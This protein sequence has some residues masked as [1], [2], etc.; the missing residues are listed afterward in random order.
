[1]WRDKIMKRRILYILII[2]VLLSAGIVVYAKYNFKHVDRNE[3]FKNS[4]YSFFASERDTINNFEGMTY[5]NMYDLG[6]FFIDDKVKSLKD[7]EENSEY[8]LI[9]NSSKYPTFKGNGII[10]NCQIKKVIKG[11]D[12][13]ENEY[14]KIYDLVAFW[15]NSG[16]FYLGGSTPIKREK[17]YIVFL[18]STTNANEPNSYVYSSVKYGHVSISE[19]GKILENYKQNSLSLEDIANYDFVF[20]EGTS[21]ESISEYNTLYSEIWNK[22]KEQ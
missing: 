18:N 7:L 10:N 4:L 2:F 3:F 20:P 6:D 17:D 12:V 8:I 5:E 21:K 14:I 11:T 13:K 16:T 1:M 9:V 19:K 22:Y 15:N